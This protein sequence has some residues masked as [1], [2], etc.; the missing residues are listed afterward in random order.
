VSLLQFL[1]SS[2]WQSEY[3][4]LDCA[5]TD[6]RFCCCRTEDFL[7][8]EVMDS[9]GIIDTEYTT[10]NLVPK[11]ERPTSRMRA[12]LPT[13]DEFHAHVQAVRDRKAAQSAAAA[14]K[15][16]K[17]K[18][19]KAKEKEEKAAAARNKQQ[20]KQQKKAREA[21]EQREKESQA[22]KAHSEVGRDEIEVER[23]ND[24]C[25]TPTLSASA[26]KA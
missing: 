19:A 7:T 9:L 16:R 12:C 11:D 4:E 17:E 13:H 8:E 6:F 14:E 1:K 5:F 10:R 3:L 23:A 22:E 24:S 20:L 18:E 2:N 15:K 26:E 21:R 25:G